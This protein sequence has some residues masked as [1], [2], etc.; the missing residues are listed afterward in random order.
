MNYMCC[1]VSEIC[2]SNCGLVIYGF[3]MA[4]LLHSSQ[5]SLNTG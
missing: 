3:E 1:A 2:N 4:P 5:V